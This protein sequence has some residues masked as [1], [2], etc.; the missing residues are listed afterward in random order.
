MMKP[1]A[2]FVSS[3]AAQSVSSPLIG[4]TWIKCFAQMKLALTLA[5]NESAGGDKLNKLSLMNEL[6]V[7]RKYV[8]QSH[9]IFSFVDVDMNKSLKRNY[10][11]FNVLRP[12]ER[13]M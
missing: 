5:G 12:G 2:R 11:G 1:R 13:R 4:R 10:L 7:K 8:T 6:P 9:R 3:A